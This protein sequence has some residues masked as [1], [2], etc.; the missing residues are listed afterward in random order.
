MVYCN[1]YALE[2]I[3][4]INSRLETFGG[5][6]VTGL[7][8]RMKVTG[9]M[10]TFVDNKSYPKRLFLFLCYVIPS[11]MCIHLYWMTGLR[12]YY[13]VCALV[14]YY[15]RN[16]QLCESSSQCGVIVLKKK[17]PYC[18]IVERRSYRKEC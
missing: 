12:L 2:L 11:F 15:C 8:N 3:K 7:K 4:Q 16:R 13:V 9:S 18:N 17:K 1:A 14:S 10:S 6:R 5:T